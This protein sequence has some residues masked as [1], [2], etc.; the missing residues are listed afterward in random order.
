MTTHDTF[1]TS[2]GKKIVEMA[3]SSNSSSRITQP[4]PTETATADSA[5]VKIAPHYVNKGLPLQSQIIG[6]NAVFKRLFDLILGGII[7]VLLMPLLIVISVLIKLDSTGPALFYQQRRGRNGE[8]IDVYKFRTMF[9]TFSTPVPTDESFIQ[10][11]KND[12]RVTRIG[13]F[14]RKTSLDELPQLLN[15]LQGNMSL[16]GP[17]PH[18]MPLDEQYKFY[19]P[20]LA[21]RYAIKPGITGWAQ[22]NG[23]RGETVNV[24]D[25]VARVEHDCHYINNW[26]LWLDI[27]ILALTA[28][29]GWKHKNAY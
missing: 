7:F 10:T 23:L 25:M 12:R 20:D 16:I 21:A 2:S 6:F 1:K 15:V 24:K 22:I 13:S 14:L 29:K 11:T 8:L 26:S 4:S 5:T 28:I 3:L 18:P 9:Q 17:R 27:K 19:I